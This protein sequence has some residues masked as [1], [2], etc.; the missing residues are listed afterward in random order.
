MEDE[1]RQE[2]EEPKAT[3]AGHN[4]VHNIKNLRKVHLFTNSLLD[5]VSLKSNQSSRTEKF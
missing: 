2:E 1:A 3:A 5:F 4:Q